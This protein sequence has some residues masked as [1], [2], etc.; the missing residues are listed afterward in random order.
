M[1]EDHGHGPAAGGIMKSHVYSPETAF[2]VHGGVWQRYLA[3]GGGSGW[4][5]YPACD[6][7]Q[8]GSLRRTDFAGGFV[9]YDPATQGSVAAPYSPTFPKLC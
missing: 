9:G 7:F 2:W 6:E 5:D 1:G 8:F 4:L 3:E